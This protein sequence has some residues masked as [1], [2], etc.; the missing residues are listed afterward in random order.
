MGMAGQYEVHLM[1]SRFGNYF[2]I[3]CQQNPGLRKWHFTNRLC[4]IAL[5]VTVLVNAG[6]PQG[7]TFKIDPFRAIPQYF[8]LGLFEGLSDPMRVYTNI[9]VSQ[10]REYAETSFEI[11]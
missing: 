9:M 4:N 6:D 2:R 11:S 3:V 5:T 8:N 7:V 1:T 10:Y